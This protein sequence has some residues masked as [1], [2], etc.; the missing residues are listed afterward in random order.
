MNPVAKTF[1]HVHDLFLFLGVTEEALPDVVPTTED[2]A[3]IL[4]AQIFTGEIPIKSIDRGDIFSITDAMRSLRN[5]GTPEW[6]LICAMIS[7]M[8]KADDLD[9]IYGNLLFNMEAMRDGTEQV[10]Y[11]SEMTPRS[12]RVWPIDSIGKFSQATP[13]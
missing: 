12:H 6:K 2:E 11:P 4:G 7:A 8:P 1:N 10:L 5:A 3:R 9:S 13:A